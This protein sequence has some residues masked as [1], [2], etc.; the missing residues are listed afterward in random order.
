MGI[1]SLK[2]ALSIRWVGLALSVM[3]AL[4]LGTA[5]PA[6]AAGKVHRMTL[7]MKE[8]KFEPDTLHLKVGERV[9]LTIKNE[10]QVE[11]E[12]VAGQG[13]VNTA[14]EQG[15]KKDLFALLKPRVTGRE[16]ELERASAKP[17]SKD[18]AEGES[19]RRLGT[20][21]DVESGGTATLRFTVPASARG[22]WDMACLLPGHYESGMKGTIL[23]E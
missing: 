17:S 20:E 3:A 13:I 2:Q 8:F 14:D 16:Y 5:S 11:H 19:V 23:I 12:W 21:I 1:T 7:V 15:F 18:T 9:I 6:A 4:A 10:G 22:Q